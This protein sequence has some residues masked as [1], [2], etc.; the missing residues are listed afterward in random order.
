M[1]VL[2]AIVALVIVAYGLTAYFGLQLWLPL[3]GSTPMWYPLVAALLALL[4]VL[5]A[6]GVMRGVRWAPFAALALS[7]IALGWTWTWLD[8]TVSW[9]VKGLAVAVPLLVIAYAVADARSARSAGRI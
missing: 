8:E 3:T 4:T 6:I 9:Q 5:T 1:K 2:G 7:L